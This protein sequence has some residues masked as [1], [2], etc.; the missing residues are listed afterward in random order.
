[1]LKELKT[2]EELD[3]MAEDWAPTWEGLRL[4]GLEEQLKEIDPAV[5]VAYCSGKTY[6]EAYCL[7]GENKY[8]DDLHIVFLTKLDEEK[9]MRWKFN[10]GCRWAWDVREN[11]LMREKQKN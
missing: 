6:N 10:Y 1:M 3:E 5:E 2:K 7:T 11:N 9:K 8:R 4:D